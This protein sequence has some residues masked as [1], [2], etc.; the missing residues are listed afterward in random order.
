[1]TKINKLLFLIIVFLNFPCL[2]TKAQLIPDKSLGNESSTVNSSKVRDLIEGGAIREGNI[3]HSFK[4]F[5]V[6]NG[7]RVYFANPD[8]ISNILTRVTGSNISRILGTLGVDGAANLFLINPNGILFGK[9]AFLDISGSFTA[10]SAESLF[11]DNYE[12]SALN[13]DETP[14]LKINLTPGLQYGKINP[15]SKIDN[16]GVLK[17]GEGENLTLLG[18]KVYHTGSLIA[19][20]GKVEISGEDVQF[21]GN[22]DTRGANGEVGILL[23]DPKN[24]LIAEGSNFSGEGISQALAVNNVILQANND[25][26]VDDDIT[27]DKANDLTL[28]AGR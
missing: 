21:T 16:Q 8:G 19:P 4:E 2:S 6:N 11:I 5:N 22:V 24:I 14:L 28:E 25:I 10:T 12:F 27:A 20:N 15:Q 1:M 13:P 23:I 7:Q 9:N 3:F 26:T 18:G 17:V